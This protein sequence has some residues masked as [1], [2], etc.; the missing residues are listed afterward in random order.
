MFKLFKW[1]ELV[2]LEADLQ[3]NETFHLSNIWDIYYLRVTRDWIKP[4]IQCKKQTLAHPHH[5]FHKSSGSQ[6]RFGHREGEVCSIAVLAVRRNK[7]RVSNI[8]TLYSFQ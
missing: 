1:Q 3:L 5:E 8:L 6:I 7:S 2:A 4:D